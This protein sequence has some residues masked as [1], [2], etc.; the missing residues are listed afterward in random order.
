MVQRDDSR[1]AIPSA[2]RFGSFTIV[3][4]PI[5]PCWN[6]AARGAR[7]AALVLITGVAMLAFWRQAAR[8][9]ALSR[10]SDE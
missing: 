2:Q 8:R 7:R 9:V 4:V 5:V 1:P 6:P 10:K 3:D